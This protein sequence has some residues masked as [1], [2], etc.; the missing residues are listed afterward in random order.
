MIAVGGIDPR[1]IAVLG[2]CLGIRAFASDPAAQTGSVHRSLT[3]SSVTLTPGES[4]QFTATVI[5]T[6]EFAKGLKWTVNEVIGG[7]STLGKISDTGLYVTP[8]P[9]PA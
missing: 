2:V 6:G 5:G 4:R 8:F 3:P 9:A 1:W 7:N